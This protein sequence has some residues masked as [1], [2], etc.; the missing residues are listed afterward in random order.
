MTASEPGDPTDDL[1]LLLD[2]A[3]AAGEVAM[4]FFA[5]GGTSARIAHKEG[6]SPVTEADLAADALLAERL[7][8]ARPGYGWLSEETADTAVRL[9]RR[10]LFVV[11]P[12]DGT[13]SFIAGRRE[14]A[15]SVAVVDGDRPIAGVVYA[16]ALGETLAAVHGRGATHNGRP[17]PQ[18]GR[19]A[20]RPLAVEG[21]RPFVE[22]LE[23]AMDETFDFRPRI[24]SLAWRLSLAALGRVDLAV[25]SANAHDWDIAAADLVLREC[26]GAL[27]DGD[28]SSPVYNRAV[29]R[30]PALFGGVAALAHRAAGAWSGLVASGPRR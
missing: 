8:A 19:D 6:G 12:I 21:P 5:E 9:D 1:A 28:G 10:R 18:L 30:H 3:L 26:G 14:W 13:R 4:R 16:P 11:D 22:T 25:A 7:L 17:L 29:P 15:V 23:R 24:Y 20:G 2:A 27:I